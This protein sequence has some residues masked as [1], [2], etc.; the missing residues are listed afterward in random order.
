MRSQTLRSALGTLIVA[1]MTSPE[2][3]MSKLDDVIDTH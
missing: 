2:H 1:F 3:H